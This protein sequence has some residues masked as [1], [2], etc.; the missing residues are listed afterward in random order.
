MKWRLV[1]PAC[2]PGLPLGALAVLGAFPGGSDRF[3][4]FGI[5]ALNA[6]LAA[7]F[8]PRQAL[9]HGAVIG[10]VNGASATMVQAVFVDAMLRNNPAMAARFAAQPPGFDPRYFVYMLV[11]FIGVAGGGLTGFLAM[12]IARVRARRETTP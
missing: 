2:L 1:L 11:P 4:W 7:R 10:F 5:V 3:V 12:A 9:L 8:A 6:W